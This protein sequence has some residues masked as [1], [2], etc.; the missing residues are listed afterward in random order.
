VA[1]L[2]PEEALPALE[3]R[4]SGQADGWRKAGLLR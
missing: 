1:P 4:T 3:R 2:V